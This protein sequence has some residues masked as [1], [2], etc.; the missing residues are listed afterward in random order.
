MNKFAVVVCADSKMVPAACCV[1]LNVHEV[2]HE[3]VDLILVGVNLDKANRDGVSDFAASKEVRIH[4]VDHNQQKFE[5]HVLRRFGLATL[6]RLFLDQ[7]LPVHY[8]RVLYLDTD[9]YLHAD[10]SE[11]ITM[12]LGATPMGAMVDVSKRGPKHIQDRAKMLGISDGAN[13]I[14]ASLL[15]FDW[16]KT[17][18]GGFL[19]KSRTALQNGKNFHYLDQDALSVGFNGNFTAIDPSWNADPFMWPILPQLNLVHFAGKT[20]PWHDNSPAM[21][22]VYRKYFEETLRGTAWSG[23]VKPRNWVTK[24]VF[25]KDNLKFLWKVRKKTYNYKRY[26]T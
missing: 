2:T 5:N 9:V 23:F 11:L 26:Y 7:L 18:A 16:Q 22:E 12:D 3:Q 25:T 19:E 20:K 10:P 14:A 1:L 17:L 13:M 6:T 24:L 21:F 8:E 4:L 15:L